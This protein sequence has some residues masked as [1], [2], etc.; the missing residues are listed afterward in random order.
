MSAAVWSEP[1]EPSVMT[2]RVSRDS[3]RT[4]GPT[5]EIRTKE[6]RTPL[7]FTSAWPP[8][9]CPIHRTGMEITR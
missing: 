9:A 6:G 3:G 8:C 4:W 5:R 1:A 7:S 2:I